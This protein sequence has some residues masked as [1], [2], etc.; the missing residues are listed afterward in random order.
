GVDLIDQ[1]MCAAAATFPEWSGKMLDE[2]V[3]CL[4]N[5]QTILRERKELFAETIARECG[6]PR[7]EALTEAGALIGK[8]DV[9]IESWLNRAKDENF[10]MGSATARTRQHALGVCVVL[11]PFNLPAHL[12]NGQIIPAL[13]AG[14]T[15]V[16][17]PSEACPAVGALLIDSLAAAFPA[18]VINMLQGARDTGV[19]LIA[20]Q[21]VA[22][23]FFTGSYRAGVAIHKHFAGRPEIMLALEM[24][25]NNPLVVWEAKDVDAVALLI[26]QSAYVTAGQRCVC[27]RRLIVPIGEEGDAYI[28]AIQNLIPRIR[29]GD[30]LA[31]EQPFVGCLIHQ[32]AA[33]AVMAAQEALLAQGASSLVSCERLGLAQISPGLIDVTS[34]AQRED[35][36]IFGPLLQVIRVANYQ[37]ALCEANNTAFGLSAGLISDNEDLYDEFVHTVRAGIINW[38]RQITGASGKLPFGGV[39]HSGNFRPG[40][41][42]AVDYCHYSSASIEA[43]K[44]EC[45]ALPTGIS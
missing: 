7:W 22:G 26:A 44:L 15:V 41:L 39:G 25:G 8:I 20:H 19:A 4:R 21:H 30:P 33:D 40:A 1:A 29:V 35:E 36:E 13:L 5:Y 31:D 23:V 6:K 37:D 27:A 24:G 34:L 17:K 3:S 42:H 2:R 32:A 10:A 12:P 28:G 16:F 43:E 45:P 11:G 38:N 9:T 18:G 14:N